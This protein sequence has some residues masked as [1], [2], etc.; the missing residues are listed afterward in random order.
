MLCNAKGYSLNQS[1]LCRIYHLG[2]LLL[3]LL[4]LNACTT[5]PR[6]TQVDIAKPTSRT[7]E[8]DFPQLI[9][10]V[11]KAH[12]PVAANRIRYWAALI[13][14]NKRSV[15]LQKLQQT[16]LFFNEARFVSDQEIW[17]LEDY[18]AT[19][20]EFLIRDAGDCEDFAIAK[21]VT[22]DLMG[23]D[24]SK[25]RITYVTA[26]SL[27]QPHMVLSYY[28]K[29]GDIPLI[30]DNITPHILPGDQRI[31]LTPVYSF[32]GTSL[33]LARSRNEQV[34]SGDSQQIK[35]WR[36][37]EYKIESELGVTID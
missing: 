20:V 7:I 17:Q 4:I 36:E 29:P 14:Q 30:L 13:E 8:A 10:K 6:Q 33:W 23:V 15:D 16:N 11:E 5:Q 21:Y 1:T 31:D 35:L 34:K 26:K 9:A 37:L 22:L 27:D 25:M 32:N 12:G 2:L 18:W 3:C 19:P 24:T 28:A